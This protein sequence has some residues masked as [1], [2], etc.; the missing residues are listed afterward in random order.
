M[1][2]KR[3]EP[4]VQ[5]WCTE[6]LCLLKALDF[7]RQFPEELKPFLADNTLTLHGEDHAVV[8]VHRSACKG[9]K[10][11]D[12]E[13]CMAYDGDKI[14]LENGVLSV[15]VYEEFHKIYKRAE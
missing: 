11:A 6:N 4:I 12:R 3:R 7:E 14:I 10:D 2:F 1:K 8:H 15:M 5:A 13:P 9:E